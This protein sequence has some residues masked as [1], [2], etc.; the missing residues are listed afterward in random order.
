[1]VGERLCGE[2]PLILWA[3]S[4]ITRPLIPYPSIP[5]PMR[6]VNF[7][8][9]SLRFCRRASISPRPCL[10][11]GYWSNDYPMPPEVG[12]VY[13]VTD[14][15]SFTSAWNTFAGRFTGLHWLEGDQSNSCLFPALSGISCFQDTHKRTP[16]RRPESIQIRV[17]SFEEWTTN[18]T[19]C[20]LCSPFAPLR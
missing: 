13:W 20:S 14:G 11:K 6:F 8:I 15:V 4:S 10:R 1:M 7:D 3:D 9:K 19:S 17:N 12:A 2:M 5:S 18:F 16:A